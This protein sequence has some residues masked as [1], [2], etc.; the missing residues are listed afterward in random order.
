MNPFTSPYKPSV[1]TETIVDPKMDIPQNDFLFNYVI[2]ANN[3]ALKDTGHSVNGKKVRNA[4]QEIEDEIKAIRE[5]L[6]G[7]IS[8]IKEENHVQFLNFMMS[9]YDY[10]HDCWKLNKDLTL[11]LKEEDSR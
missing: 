10:D 4:D 2:D 1:Y 7:K 8:E 11:K 3:E 5:R 6:R 9:N